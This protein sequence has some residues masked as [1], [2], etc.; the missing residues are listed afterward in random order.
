MPGRDDGVRVGRLG[1]QC[2]RA[3]KAGQA[4]HG[5]L[6]PSKYDPQAYENPTGRRIQLDRPAVTGFREAKLSGEPGRLRRD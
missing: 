4:V 3:I 1:I 6:E 5:S 2:S